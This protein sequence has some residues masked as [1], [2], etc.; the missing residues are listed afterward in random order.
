[1]SYCIRDKDLILIKQRRKIREGGLVFL[2]LIHEH[3]DAQFA[4]FR[5]QCFIHGFRY[6]ENQSGPFRQIRIGE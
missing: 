6:D 5:L 2:P 3:T 4:E 1:M